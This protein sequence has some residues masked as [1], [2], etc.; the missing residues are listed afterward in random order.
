MSIERRAE[1][2][3]AKAGVDTAPVPVKQVADHLGNKSSN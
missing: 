2:L 1:Q 3:L